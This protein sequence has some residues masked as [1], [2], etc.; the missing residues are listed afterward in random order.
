MKS[1]KTK[2]YIQQDFEDDKRGYR[3]LY[4]ML[5]AGGTDLVYKKFL[6]LNDQQTKDYWVLLLNDMLV[7]LTGLFQC[8]V[9]EGNGGY[10]KIIEQITAE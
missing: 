7:E 9:V 2:V 8:T 10:E 4:A 5:A 3:Q 1:G 6:A